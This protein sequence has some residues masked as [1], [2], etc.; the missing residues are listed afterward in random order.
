MR[1]IMIKADFR[2]RGICKTDTTLN[3]WIRDEG[4]PP[5]FML[6]VSAAGMRTR[7]RRGLPPDRLARARCAV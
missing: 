3:R 7:L 4:F 1:R 2:S 6:G 5:G